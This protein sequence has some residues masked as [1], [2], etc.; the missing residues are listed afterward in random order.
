[1]K[2]IVTGSNGLVG[3]ALVRQC[4]ANDG[5]SHVFAL[6]RKRL[7]EAVAKSPKVTV[8]LHDDFSTYPQELLDKVKG[9]EGCLW[10]IGGR[11]TQFPDIDTYRKVQVDYTITAANAFRETLVPLLPEGSHF[12]FVFCSGKLAEWDQTKTLHFMADTRRV[13][14]QVEQR[15]CQVADA[16]A[17][18]RFVVYC[19]RP[20]RILPAN[21][22]LAARVF[23]KLYGAIGVDQ[24]AKALIRVLLEGYKERI[25]ENGTLLTL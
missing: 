8:I 14:G 6:S 15:L 23:G 17:A 12:R 13:K 22:G 20:S 5:I 4:M 18:K 10:A 3:S 25:I 2:V 7:D 16:D 11:A 1:M 9:A 19:A 21:A 24:L